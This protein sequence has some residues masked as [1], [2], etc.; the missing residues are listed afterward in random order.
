MDSHV[1]DGEALTEAHIEG[2]EVKL[3]SACP[4]LHGDELGR[5]GGS[6]EDPHTLRRHRKRVDSPQLEHLPTHHGD[7]TGQGVDC[8]LTIT[9]CCTITTILDLTMSN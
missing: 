6:G 8:K 4:H 1:T 5:G 2:G 7:V 9:P 3:G